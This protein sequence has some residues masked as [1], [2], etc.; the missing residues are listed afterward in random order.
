[1]EVWIR[2]VIS[3]L[4]IALVAIAIVFL[5]VFGLIPAK[6]L[7]TVLEVEEKRIVRE[8][9]VEPEE[10]PPQSSSSPPPPSSQQPP[11]PAP[12]LPATSP[13]TKEGQ[14]VTA[15]GQPVRL[16]VPPGTPLAPQQSNPISEDVLPEEAIKLKVSAEG[17]SPNSF[18]VSAG[19]VV[20]LSVSSVDTQTHL[21]KF[22]SPALSAVAIG[23]APGETRAITF[24][25]PQAVGEYEFLCDVPGHEARGER[26]VMVVK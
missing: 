23:V 26:G 16:D 3:V 18:S 20:I 17:F 5:G 4:F 15:E 24:N 14:V 25:A 2:I 13:V 19:S 1:M 9:I 21:F 7:T 8:K 12:I 11:L 22:K 10:S 6:K